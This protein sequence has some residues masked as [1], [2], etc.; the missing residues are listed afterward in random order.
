MVK[1]CLCNKNF[2]GF[3]HNPS[4]LKEN[5]LCCNDC[6]FLKVIPARVKAI[7]DKGDYKK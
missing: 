2:E 7:K 3:G 5:A 1:C 6:N 4:P